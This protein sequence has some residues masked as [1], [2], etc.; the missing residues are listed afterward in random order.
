MNPSHHVCMTVA[1]R[2]EVRL[3]L[4]RDEAF[5]KQNAQSK[6][7]DCLYAVFGAHFFACVDIV[8]LFFAC[9]R[10]RSGEAATKDS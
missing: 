7:F 8:I 1:R 9:A 4:S 6:T 5:A 10:R 3:F 2:R